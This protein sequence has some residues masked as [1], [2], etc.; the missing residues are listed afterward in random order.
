MNVDFPFI[1][2]GMDLKTNRT[3]TESNE[4]EFE[5]HIYN[6][7]SNGKHLSHHRRR[8]HTIFVVRINVSPFHF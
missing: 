6:Y 7:E 2:D 1:L 5:I 3:L 8:L 4:Y